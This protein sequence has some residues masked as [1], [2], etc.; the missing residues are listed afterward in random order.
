M[1]A[2]QK[3]GLFVLAV[4]LCGCDRPGDNKPAVQYQLT[5]TARKAVVEYRLPD[6]SVEQRTVAIP[7]TSQKYRFPIGSDVDVKARNTGASGDLRVE[8][9]V[10]GYPDRGLAFDPFTQYTTNAYGAV[11]ASC[12]VSAK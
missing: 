10:D 8:V 4:T 12:L 1:E 5:G 11:S 9:R 3:V 7:F 2:V 6:G